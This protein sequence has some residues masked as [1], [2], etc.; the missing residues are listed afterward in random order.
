[1]RLHTKIIVGIFLFTVLL[2]TAVSLQWLEFARKPFPVP[3]EGVVIDYYPGDSVTMFA[4]RM[5]KK[6]PD[7]VHYSSRVTLGRIRPDEFPRARELHALNL[8]E[9]G[10]GHPTV[11][12]RITEEESMAWAAREIGYAETD[13]ESQIII[14][15]RAGEVLGMVWWRIESNI[16]DTPTAHIYSLAVFPE[17]RRMG[18]GRK[19]L[20]EM[21]RR[22]R[23]D[24][25][26]KY[27]GLNVFSHNTHAMNLYRSF[28]FF[29]TAH[30]MLMRLEPTR[31][32]R[33]K[34][35]AARRK[36]Q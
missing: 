23:K 10:D 32:E 29:S 22:M 14:A 28:G 25:R 27:L 34:A 36:S 3:A 4:E 17:V 20:D 15:R 9:N 11:S 6:T 16:F 19:L 1:M 33:D 12:R 8:R 30:T 24:G 7:P 13:E 35:E 5:E 21:R 26:I 2:L 18:V 31:P